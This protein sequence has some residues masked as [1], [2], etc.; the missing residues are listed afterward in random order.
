MKAISNFKKASNILILSIILTII[1][2]LILNRSNNFLAMAIF[3]SVMLL[4]LTLSIYVRRGIAWIR[5][6]ILFLILLGSI[7]F[8]MSIQTYLT[9]SISG[10][11]NLTVTLL[12]IYAGI[13]L[14][15][16]NNKNRVTD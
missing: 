3:M 9:A 5:F 1:N 13:L 10:I 7:S 11:M 8:I 12:Q 6:L 14:I 2:I 16:G 15:I 4:L